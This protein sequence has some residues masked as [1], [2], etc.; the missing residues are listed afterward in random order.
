MQNSTK[1][2][3]NSAV[4]GGREYSDYAWRAFFVL[5]PVVSMKPFGIHFM[6]SYY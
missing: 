4:I 1:I 3:I 6:G 2:F 5:I